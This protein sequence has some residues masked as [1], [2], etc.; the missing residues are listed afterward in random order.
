VATL[1]AARLF[2][3]Y[4]DSSTGGV[5]S[6]DFRI[7]VPDDLVDAYKAASNWSAYAAYI[8]PLSDLS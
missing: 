5:P 4:N 1:T 2:N 3:A 7:Y 8:V 6:S